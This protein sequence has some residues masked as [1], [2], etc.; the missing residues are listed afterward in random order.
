MSGVRSLKSW[1]KP[2]TREEIELKHL[3]LFQDSRMRVEESVEFEKKVNRIIPTEATQIVIDLS[4][5]NDHTSVVDLVVENSSEKEVIVVLD[6]D[7]V[8]KAFDNML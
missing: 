7:N 5:S 4:E 3:L 1:F 8:F 2:L 6:N